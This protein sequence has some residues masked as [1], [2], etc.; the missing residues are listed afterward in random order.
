MA[1]LVA[2]I[3]AKEKGAFVD[4]ISHTYPQYRHLLI[5]LI[6]LFAAV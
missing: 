5:L 2:V 1:V 6:L 3:F 4:R